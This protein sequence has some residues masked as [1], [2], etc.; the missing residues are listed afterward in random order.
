MTRGPVHA[1]SLAL[2]A[3]L[4]AGC[5]DLVNPVDAQSTTY[6]GEQVLREPDE[7]PRVL[8]EVVR[9]QI[10]V[11]YDP[12][13]GYQQSRYF[14]FDIPD[15]GS[16]VEPR[17][18][19]PGRR[20]FIVAT[21][22]ERPAD[23]AFEDGV[24]VWGANGSAG[25]W[26]ETVQIASDVPFDAT[27]NS[28]RMVVE[29]APTIARAKVKLVDRNGRV[30]GQARLSFLVG[31]FNGDATVDNMNDLLSPSGVE[32]YDGMFTSGALE[33]LVRADMDAD[34]TVESAGPGMF[35][36]DI[37]DAALGADLAAFDFPA[38]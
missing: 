36:Y 5:H 10:L 2:M 23:N 14:G 26:V 32:A 27:T 35:D 9:W 4:L 28:L 7:P 30:A 38:F 1:A 33:T 31:D 21:F 8:P 6:A 37:V 25:S 15:D 20:F 19:A 16:L 29:P 18:P 24:F 3:L 34:G 17:D 22:A 12:G 13:L 11:D